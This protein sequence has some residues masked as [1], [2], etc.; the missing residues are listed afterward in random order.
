MAHLETR[1][2]PP[3]RWPFALL[4]I[5]AGTSVTVLVMTL[6]RVRAPD[7][8]GAAPVT[9]AARAQASPRPALART[10]PRLDPAGVERP[11]LAPAAA[12][13]PAPEP[14]KRLATFQAKIESHGRDGLD[15]VWASQTTAAVNQ[16]LAESSPQGG[17]A[18]KGVD[19]RRRSCVAQLEW[20]S[21][22]AASE[23]F[24]A[25]V[26][27]YGASCASEIVLPPTDAPDRPYRANLF[28][29]CQR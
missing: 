27:G 9:R 12:L 14:D 24:H 29:A 13:P 11:D 18:V 15:P 17:F 21:Y 28:L 2:R 22:A 5:L 8:A 3:A 16:V 20:P 19:C 4:G 23:G 7:P 6:L 1:A 10:A 26:G 25:V